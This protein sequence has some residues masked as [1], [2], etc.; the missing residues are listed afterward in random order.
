MKQEFTGTWYLPEFSNQKI[1]GLLKIDDNS[2]YLTLYSNIDF[3]GRKIEEFGQSIREHY[4][5]ILG[6]TNHQ[7]LSIYNAEFEHSSL[8]DANLTIFTLSVD[9]VI[10]GEHLTNLVEPL[11]SSITISATYLTHWMDE[12]EFIFQK[13]KTPLNDLDSRVN[14]LIAIDIADDYKIIID[15]FVRKKDITDR[16]KLTYQI[17][18]SIIIKSAKPKS[19]SEFQSKTNELK[20]FMELGIN[21]PIATYATSL[22]DNQDIHKHL[23]HQAKRAII[24]NKDQN[25]FRSRHAML[26]S[27][28]ILGDADF[29]M[30]TQNWFRS[31]DTHL[32]IYD[33]FLDTYLWFEGTEAYISE[34]MFKNRVLNIIQGL[35]AFH[36]I[37]FK[38]DDETKEEFKKGLKDMCDKLSL[39]TEDKNWLG[40]RTHP[41]SKTLPQRLQYILT[42][43]PFITEGILISQQEATTFT[44]DLC[45]IRNSLSHGRKMKPLRNNMSA[46]YNVSRI[47]LLC[48]ILKN[49]G[50]DNKRITELIMRCDDYGPTL[51]Y[52]RHHKKAMQ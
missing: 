36:T 11:F 28:K 5:V 22:G 1:S 16:H 32:L 9:L 39:S 51:E 7:K 23:V 19:Y 35:E 46:L 50:L 13:L 52:L 44:E 21:T 24:V 47:L 45:E 43:F 20:R 25:S 12:Q 18:H 49:L 41:A 48:Y 29:K 4:P 31:I 17:H 26:F 37:E 15:R 33:I 42:I 8:I 38:G 6:D 3:E 2:I 34:V 30:V 14:K 40:K 27:Y 10:E